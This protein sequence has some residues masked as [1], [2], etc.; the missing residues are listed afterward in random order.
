MCSAGIHAEPI[1]SQKCVISYNIIANEGNARKGTRA[2]EQVIVPA[3]EVAERPFE[4]QRNHFRQ[5][6]PRV[7][8]HCTW[9]PTVNDKSFR[10]LEVSC[11]T[12]LQVI[13]SGLRSKNVTS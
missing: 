11:N 4:F 8:S 3:V 7:R 5:E 13:S 10:Y 2:R 1:S 12:L 6:A 9:M